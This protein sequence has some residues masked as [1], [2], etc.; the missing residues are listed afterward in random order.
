MYRVD[1]ACGNAIP[2]ELF[3]AGTQVKCGQCG[4]EITVPNSITLKEQSGDKHPFL[5]SIEKLRQLRNSGDPPFDGTCQGCGET[6]ALWEIPA[7]MR[8]LTERILDDDGGIRPSA[9]GGVK[10]VV[11][12]GEEVWRVVRIPLLLCTNCHELLE[13]DRRAAK[14]RKLFGWLFL[15][16]LSGGFLWYGHRHDELPVAILIVFAII[17]ACAKVWAMRSTGYVEPYAINWLRK[18]DLAADIINQEEEFELTLKSAKPYHPK[19]E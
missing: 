18:I 9:T 7:S 8:I 2:V 6:E 13:A 16:A 15:F 1:C 11:S 17:V 10:F 4:T 19:D 3:Q 12:A 5:N 14:F